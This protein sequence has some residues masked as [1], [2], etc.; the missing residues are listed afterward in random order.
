MWTR[1]TKSTAAARVPRDRM[2][3]P[4]P[5][6]LTSTPAATLYRRRHDG[7]HGDGLPVGVLAVT[8]DHGLQGRGA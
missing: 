2:K 7:R 6:S 3:V 5:V 1:E 8:P 4:A